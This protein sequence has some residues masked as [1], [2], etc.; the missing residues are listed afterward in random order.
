MYYG[1]GTVDRIVKRQ[2]ADAAAYTAWA[3]DTGQMLHVQSP[4]GSVFMCEMMSWPPSWK[5]EEHCPN[6]KKEEQQKQEEQQYGISSWSKNH[7]TMNTR[8]MANSPDQPK[9]AGGD[10]MM[11]FYVH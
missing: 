7:K 10:D 9:R 11:K 4:D 5:Y 3:A 8:F 1:P 6:N 2:P